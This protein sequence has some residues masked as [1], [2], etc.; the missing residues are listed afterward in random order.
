MPVFFASTSRC[1]IYTDG[2]TSP[3]TAFPPNLAR[4][5]F[6]TALNYLRVIREFSTTITLPQRN[7]QTSGNQDPAVFA[8]HTVLNHG[9]GYAPLTFGTAIIGGVSAPLRG[10]VMVQLARTYSGTDNPSFAR[11]VSLGADATRV[12]LNE[13]CVRRFDAAGRVIYPAL[14][15]PVTVFLTDEAL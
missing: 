14:S 11:F 4:V 6:D 3:E 2:D 10:S 15:L 5:K 9:L 13:Y 7:G 12:V 1:V 8:N